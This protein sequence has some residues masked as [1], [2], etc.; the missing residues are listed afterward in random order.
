MST[1]FETDLIQ[2]ICRYIETHQEQ[3]LTLDDLAAQAQL[4][5]AHFQKRFK[6]IIG[7]S[8]KEYLEAC[9][10]K[11]LKQHLRDTLQITDAIY[12]TGFGSSSRV[13]EKINSHIGMTPKQYQGKGKNISISYAFLETSFGLILLGATDRGLCFVQFGENEPELLTKLYHEFPAAMIQEMTNEYAVQ[14]EEWKTAL[15]DY[16][17][18]NHPL[19]DL[20]LDIHGTAFQRQIWK[21]LQ[22]IPSGDVQSYTQVA[23]AVGKP[24]AVRAVAS[25]CAKNTIALVIPCHRVIR[26]SGELAGYRWGL[27]RKRAL[28]DL[29]K[30]DLEK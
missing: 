27:Q 11:S 26:G 20:S 9:R 13:Y 8:P 17:T 12:Q 24:N 2:G 25:A 29:E 22:T 30:L 28:L 7:I 18:G 15:T 19:P 3:S 10:L 21:Y 14:L 23:H 4:S 1:H 6:A 16:L 5:P